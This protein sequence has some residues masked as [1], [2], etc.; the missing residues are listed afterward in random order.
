[1][2]Y[3]KAMAKFASMSELMK[4]AYE[5]IE[6]RYD[7]KAPVIGLASGFD[8][9]DKL[10]SGFQ[11]G[12]LVIVAARPSMGKSALALNMAANAA[13]RSDAG[14]A[15]FSLEMSAEEVA[16]RLLCA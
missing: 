2:L 7:N 5:A 16:E 4:K 15:I 9:L 14:V 3:A 1:M 8:A 13:L 11:P 12:N 10:T 6:R